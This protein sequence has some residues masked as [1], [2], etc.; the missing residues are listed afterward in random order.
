ME[1]SKLRI[2]EMIRFENWLWKHYNPAEVF[3]DWA[4]ETTKALMA[5]AEAAELAPSDI[6]L[7]LSEKGIYNPLCELHDL[8][9][10]PLDKRL[11]GE[12]VFEFYPGE[13]L[14]KDELRWVALHIQ[15]AII[16]AE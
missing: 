3:A 14:T 15:S 6:V 5:L 16:P 11:P 8:F 13:A 10:T 1:K 2:N 9:L 7:P 4:D 12:C